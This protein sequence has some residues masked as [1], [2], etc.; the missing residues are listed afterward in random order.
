VINYK[1]AIVNYIKEEAWNPNSF[2]YIEEH[3][4]II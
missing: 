4:S 1:H 2:S 3:L